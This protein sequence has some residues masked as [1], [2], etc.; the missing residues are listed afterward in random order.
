MAAG[1]PGGRGHLVEPKKIVG[2]ASRWSW[3]RHLTE[4]QRVAIDNTGLTVIHRG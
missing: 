3:A 1:T 4:E 2:P